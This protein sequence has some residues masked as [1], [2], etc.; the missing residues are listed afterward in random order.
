MRKL[1]LLGL[2]IILSLACFSQNYNIDSSL[3][4][5]KI[6]KD[7]TLHALKLQRDS[8]YNAWMHNDTIKTDKEF[9]NDIKW[10]KLKAITTYPAIKGGE[11]SGVITV[12]DPTEIPDP[13]IDYKLLFE[14]TDNNPDSVAKEVNYGLTEVARKINLHV[15]SG[16]PVKKI[17]PVI[18]VHGGALYAFTNN[19]V[20][21]EKYKTDNPNI[22]L[23][24]DLE[25]MGARFIA[26]GQAMAFLDI[27]REALLPVMKVSVT[28]QTVL[29]SY[30]LKGYVL[31]QVS[32]K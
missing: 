31:F 6:K 15:A 9:K 23:I 14:L 25:A 12:K 5:L 10:E 28:A 29:S 13:K 3:A 32:A 24:S 19:E 21:K 26:C 30:Q 11:Y 8:A 2:L 20:Y 1:S 18:L 17:F 22:K 7:S 4:S 27:K 16:V